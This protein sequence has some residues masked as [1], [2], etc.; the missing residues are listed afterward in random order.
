MVD[1]NMYSKPNFLTAIHILQ[2][3]SFPERGTVYDYYFQKQSSGSWV[4]WLSYIDKSKT[5][6]PNDAKVH[7]IF[8]YFIP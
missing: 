1:H 4:E 2:S 6:I 3:N 5:L 8:L 7:F